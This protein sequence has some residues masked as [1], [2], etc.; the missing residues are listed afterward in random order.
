MSLRLECELRRSAPT[1]HLPVIALIPA[2]RSTLGGQIWDAS[3]EIAEFGVE[4]TYFGVQFRN[5]L[6]HRSH[7]LLAFGGVLAR[8]ARFGDFDAGLIPFGLK[9]L[10]L[11]HVL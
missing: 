5:T 8:F 1:P 3:Q 7:L 2:N 4:L 11:C 10:A 9:L 6:P